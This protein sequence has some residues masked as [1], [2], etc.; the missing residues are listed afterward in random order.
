ML[1]ACVTVRP[2]FHRSTVSRP[3]RSLI[4]AGVLNTCLGDAQ[5][6]GLRENLQETK[7][8]TSKYRGFRLKFSHHPILWDAGE[9]VE[10]LHGRSGSEAGHTD[11]FDF[12]AGVDGLR[13]CQEC[14]D[15]TQLLAWDSKS[16]LFQVAK[17]IFEQKHQFYCLTTLN[18][19]FGCGPKGPRKWVAGRIILGDILR[20]DRPDINI[21]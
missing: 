16:Q 11:F 20:I 1:D 14:L 21:L 4:L 7:F 6:I 10:K 19:T 15:G 5:W 8:F 2:G 9:K 3:W 12:F 18:P 17:D 13:N